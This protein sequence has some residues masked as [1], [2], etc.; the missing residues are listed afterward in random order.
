MP[1]QPIDMMPAIYVQPR[2]VPY[3]FKKY[4]KISYAR[5][6]LI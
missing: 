6:P 1:R 2:A 4:F 5:A 3:I